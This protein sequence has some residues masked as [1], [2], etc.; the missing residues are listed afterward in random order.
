MS[1]SGDLYT[2]IYNAFA[3][4]TGAGGLRNATGNQYVNPVES[5]DRWGDKDDRNNQQWPTVN[6]HVGNTNED[7]AFE[8]GRAVVVGR[9]D[10]R[11]KRDY[12]EFAKIDAVTT[13]IRTLYHRATLTASTDW[14]WSPIVILREFDGPVS[15]NEIGR[16]VEFRVVATRTSGVA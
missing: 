6:V 16:I 12:G 11:V 15:G 7:D 13:R 1:L 4:D 5:F 3:A 10:V 14:A 2:A 9:F 8:R